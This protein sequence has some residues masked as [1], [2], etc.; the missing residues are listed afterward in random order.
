LEFEILSLTLPQFP[1]IILSEKGGSMIWLVSG[2]IIA[3]ILY[4]GF[5]ELRYRRILVD[6]VG[7]QVPI[8]SLFATDKFRNKHQESFEIWLGMR[9]AD[10]LFPGDE[11]D[12]PY[13]MGEL[14]NLYYCARW[15]GFLVKASPKDYVKT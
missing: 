4:W 10:V 9:G 2:C 14:N 7:P 1:S 13:Y 6:C 15:Y 8:L 5:L 3:G 12:R 11:R